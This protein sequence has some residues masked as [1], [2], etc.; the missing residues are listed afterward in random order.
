MHCLSRP[1]ANWAPE[2]PAL[3]T[4][5]WSLR[6]T[7]LSSFHSTSGTQNF[8]GLRSTA[9]GAMEIVFD[10]GAAQRMVWRVTAPAKAEARIVEALRLAIDQARVLPALYSELTKR[11]I[12]IEAVTQTE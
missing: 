7:S 6:M 2:G 8:L 1:R 10:D 4:G 9:S 5:G 11:S 3:R 12:A